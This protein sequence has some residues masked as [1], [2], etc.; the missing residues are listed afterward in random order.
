MPVIKQNGDIIAKEMILS[1]YFVLLFAVG[2]LCLLS[3]KNSDENKE[4]ND[5]ISIASIEPEVSGDVPENPLPAGVIDADTISV[6]E[7]S[8]LFAEPVDEAKIIRRFG[9]PAKRE[10]GDHGEVKLKYY[11]ANAGWDRDEG[12]FAKGIDINFARSGNFILWSLQHERMH[13]VSE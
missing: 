7:L 3:C 13:R 1:H 8:R 4:R 2:P 12:F 10:I 9:Q 11:F 5:H 6:G